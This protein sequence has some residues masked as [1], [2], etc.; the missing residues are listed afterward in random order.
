MPSSFPQQ[1]R[2]DSV[3]RE[4]LVVMHSIQHEIFAT[5]HCDLYK[6]CKPLGLTS[7]SCEY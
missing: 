4:Q 2:A 1:V 7:S 5:L 6:A 3:G